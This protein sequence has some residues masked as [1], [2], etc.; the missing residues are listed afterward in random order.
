MNLQTRKIGIIIA[1]FAISFTIN[2][3]DACCPPENNETKTSL[4]TPF[5]IMDYKANVEAATKVEN[6]HAG[7]GHADGEC[8]AATNEDGGFELTKEQQ[9][10][11]KIVLD[12]ASTGNLNKTISIPGEII[13]NED[14]LVHL[15]PRVAGIA[16]D[17]KNQIGDKVKKGDLI[18]VLD[19]SDFG[20]IKSEYY[21]IYSDVACCTLDLVRAEE[22]AEN[23]IKLLADLAKYPSLIDLRKK[24][25][26]NLGAYRATLMAAYA[27]FVLAKNIFEQKSKLYKDKI[28]SDTD[29]LAIQTS[30]DKASSAYYAECDKAQYEAKRELSLWQKTNRIAHVKQKAVKQKLLNL[31]MTEK[32]VAALET[33]TELKAKECGCGNKNCPT[34]KKKAEEEEKKKD[35]GEIEDLEIMEILNLNTTYSHFELKAPA[36]GTIIQRHIVKGE[37][38]STENEIFT[39]ADLNS[40]WAN[41]NLSKRYLSYIKKGDR[42]SILS[43]N[44]QRTSGIIDIIYPI[45]DSQTRMVTTRVVIDNKS[46]KWKPGSFITGEIS[47]AVDRLPVVVPKNAVQNIDGENVVFVEVKTGFKPIPV[48]IGESD[49]N[50]VEIISGL[51]VGRTY[52]KEGAFK[53]KAQMITSNMDPHAGHG[54]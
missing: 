12:K 8:S 22:V 29:F 1:S 53:L 20:E 51:T 25:Y 28:I 14:K 13:L 10:D 17:I 32:E 33:I 11:A 42:I 49:K 7:H 23:T 38:L 40:V 30:W 26:G 39:I 15:V 52:V 44:G 34:C 37:M 46:G 5:N 9:K 19:S 41:L 4:M 21:E 36:N 35:E 48:T 54:H 24:D 2:A 16:I 43:N 31:G 18:A 45:V 50:N 6:S 3:G 27:N 47:V